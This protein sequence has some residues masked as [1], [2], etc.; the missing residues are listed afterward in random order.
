MSAAAKTAPDEVVRELF[1]AL[2]ALDLAGIEARF[3]D[4]VQG[5]DE[6]SAGWRRGRTA[7][8]AYLESVVSAGISDLRS[9]ISDLSSVEWD[10]TAV[11]TLVLDLTYRMGRAGERIH[12]PTSIVLRRTDG[13]WRCALLHSVPVAEPEE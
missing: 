2:D 11:V 9:E 13:E 1:R 5:V 10:D 6:R 3:T 4:D 12:A 8:H 7:V